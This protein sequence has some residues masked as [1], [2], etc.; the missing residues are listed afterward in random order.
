MEIMI[1]IIE[2]LDMNISVAQNVFPLKPKKKREFFK[3][4]EIDTKFNAIK[5]IKW[6]YWNAGPNN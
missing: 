6:I 1:L 2:S 5:Q 3:F 4:W